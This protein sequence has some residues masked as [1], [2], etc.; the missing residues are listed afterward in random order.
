MSN[1]NKVILL[2]RLGRDPEMRNTQSGSKIA[3]LRLATSEKWRK[4]GELVE[5]TE[6][7]TVVIFDKLAEIAEQYATKGS[8]VY[9]EGQMQTRKW[10]D[11]DGQDRY[12][13]EIVLPKFGGVFQ[14]VGGKADGG[15]SR[16]DAGES[17]AS[18]PSAQPATSTADYGDDIP[19]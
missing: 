11:K 14:M 17:R 2:G 7:H 18:K 16:S 12:S 1:V 6:W 4:D 10:K 5:R 19:F 8:L 13:T 9:I 15:G 3:N